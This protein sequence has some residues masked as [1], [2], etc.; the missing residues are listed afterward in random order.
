MKRLV[1]A[2]CGAAAL[3]IASFATQASA[4]P[5]TLVNPLQGSDVSSQAENVAWRRVCNPQRRWI[6]GHR[7]VVNRCSNVW[8][9]GG[10]P[11]GP[12][13][14]YGPGPRPGYGPGPRVGYAPGPRPG[15]Y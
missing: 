6:N 15:Y 13:Y 12:R 7:V 2:M 5:L 8:V 9:G 3:G 1:V 10:R 4:A 11:G 14:G